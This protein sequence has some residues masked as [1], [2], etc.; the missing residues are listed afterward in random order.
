MLPDYN[1]RVEIDGIS[2]GFKKVTGL[3]IEYETI[4]Y[5]ESPVASGSPGPRK[6][7]MPGQRNTPEGIKLTKGV[8]GIDTYKAMYAWINS[9]QGTRVNKKDIHVRLLDANGDAVISWKVISA[10]PTGLEAPEFDADGKD[11][12]VETMTLM[13]DRVVIELA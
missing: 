2:V 3:N 5:A 11:V 8:A 6:I 1:Y 7:H 13:A 9:I 12:A 4:S 10:F